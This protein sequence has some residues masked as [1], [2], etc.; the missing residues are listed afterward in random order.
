MSD[1]TILAYLE[2]ADCP[3]ELRERVASLA[4]EGRAREELPHLAEHRLRLLAASREACC[5]LECLDLAIRIISSGEPCG[6]CSCDNSGR[7]EAW[8]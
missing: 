6:G 1:E 5:K 8:Q 3:P 4:R 7:R 2:R